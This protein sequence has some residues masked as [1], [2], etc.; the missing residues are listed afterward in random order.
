MQLPAN[1]PEEVLTPLQYF[2]GFITDKMMYLCVEHINIYNTQKS[3]TSINISKA[4]L[5]QLLGM[6][7]RMGLAQML[8]VQS[9]WESNM[10]YNMVS[11][12]MA[13]NRF[14]KLISLLHF[15]NNLS[16]T[17][18][19]R[20]EDK[21]WKIMPWLHLRKSAEENKCVDEIMIAFKGRCSLYQFI[22]NKPT[23]GF[24]MWMRVG[25][26][27]YLYDFN[28]YQCAALHKAKNAPGEGLG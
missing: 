12:V 18:Q 28:I 15:K 8:S 2:R 23:W 20:K 16:V 7:L 3:G 27:G 21:L 5:E 4:E 14:Q 1:T 13:R 26:S 10:A 19:A 11:D 9:Y 22:Q 25:S 17:E 24:K 6:Y